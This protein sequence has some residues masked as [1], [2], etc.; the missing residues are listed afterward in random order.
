MGLVLSGCCVHC[1]QPVKM[2]CLTSGTPS[3]RERERECVYVCMCVAVCERKPLSG[4]CVVWM[5]CPLSAACQDAPS[6]VRYPEFTRE[7]ERECVRMYVCSS[8]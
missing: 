5:L 8:L 3:L 1:Q 6:Y 4:S 2:F 7:R